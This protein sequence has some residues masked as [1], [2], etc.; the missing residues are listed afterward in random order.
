VANYDYVDNNVPVLARI[1]AKRRAAYQTLG[2][3]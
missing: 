2:K 3:G 1:A